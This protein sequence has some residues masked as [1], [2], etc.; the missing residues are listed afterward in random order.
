MRCILAMGLCGL[1]GVLRRLLSWSGYEKKGMVQ[2]LRTHREFL[3]Q[4]Y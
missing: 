3:L 1:K 4:S 2:N